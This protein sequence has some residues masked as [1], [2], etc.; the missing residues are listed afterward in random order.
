LGRP[1]HS[2]NE[3]AVNLRKAVFSKE[4]VFSKQNRMTPKLKTAKA[5]PEGEQGIRNAVWHY[6]LG[7]TEFNEQAVVLHDPSENA[8]ACEG[9][10][11]LDEDGCPLIFSQIAEAVLVACRRKNRF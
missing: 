10:L 8:T 11:E 6:M 9:P 2:N 5:S 1:S 4:A 7:S 3:Q